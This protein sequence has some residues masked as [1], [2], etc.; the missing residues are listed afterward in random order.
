MA[1]GLLGATALSA[2]TWAAVYTVP[3]AK[4][5]VCNISFCNRNSSAATIR[6]GFGTGSSPASGEYRFYDYPIGAA[7]TDSSTVVLTGVCLDAAKNVLAYASAAN[8]DVVV[9]GLEQ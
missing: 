7:G 4:T 9:D 1:S 3:T 2:T 8:I 6:L 5:A